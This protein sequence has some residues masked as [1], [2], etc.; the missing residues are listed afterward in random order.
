MPTLFDDNGRQ[1]ASFGQIAQ[2]HRNRILRY[3]SGKALAPSATTETRLTGKHESDRSSSVPHFGSVFGLRNDVEHHERLWAFDIKRLHLAA[4][5]SDIKHLQPAIE[6][7]DA[8]RS[9][10]IGV[11]NLAQLGKVAD[12][13]L[14]SLWL[15]SYEDEETLR[16]HG[17]P[18]LNPE[19]GL[20]LYWKFRRIQG[21]IPDLP[22][23]TRVEMGNSS[24]RNAKSD[25]NVTEKDQYCY[26]VD[27]VTSI[28]AHIACNSGGSSYWKVVILACLAKISTKLKAVAMDLP[29]AIESC[30]SI[31]I[32]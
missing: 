30:T 25:L 14:Y 5:A 1:E 15:F 7:N 27:Q 19:R 3:C 32:A 29:E 20:N 23:N 11:E 28:L 13:I 12:Q 2:A 21:Q 8:L 4:E 10:S 6:E 22:F 17:Y 26:I 18:P 24:K 31:T 9:W 16:S